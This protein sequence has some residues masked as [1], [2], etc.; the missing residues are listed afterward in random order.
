M[1]IS[2]PGL[3]Y[4]KLTSALR[5]P[6]NKITDQ[7]V[8]LVF[9]YP[10]LVD[11]SLRTYNDLLRDFVA[12]NILKE[13]FV[14]NAINMVSQASQIFPVTD[15][16]GQ[17]TDVAKIT[18]EIEHKVDSY[19]SYN[20]NNNKAISIPRTVDKNEIQQQ[21]K[22]KTNVIRNL[23]ISDPIYKALKPHI[24]LITMDNMID[25]PI[26]V[27]TKSYGIDSL[28]AT[29]ML[30]VCLSE[31]GSLTL[32]DETHVQQIF[33][34]IKTT[35]ASDAWTLLK[36]LSNRPK[37]ERGVII[38]WFL[39][40]IDRTKQF[41]KNMAIKTAGTINTSL[42]KTL[43]KTFKPETLSAAAGG[44][45]LA[46]TSVKDVK[47]RL[48]NIKADPFTQDETLAIL[49]T[50]S[51][52]IE[53]AEL[54][55]KFAL[56]KGLM[57]SQHGVDNTNN[58]ID[59]S[60]Q[61]IGGPV[62]SV[63]DNFHSRFIKTLSVYGMQVIQSY[64]NIFY[65]LGYVVDTTAL[66]RD[67]LDIFETELSKYLKDLKTVVQDNLIKGNSK[68]KVDRLKNLCMNDFS[69][70]DALARSLIDMLTSPG[71]YLNSPIFDFND[72]ERYSTKLDKI[73]SKTSYNISRFEKSFI[74]LVE[75]DPLLSQIG[76]FINDFFNGLQ[77][78]LQK[79]YNVDY[80]NVAIAYVYDKK[81]ALPK[82]NNQQSLNKNVI[83]PIGSASASYI[84]FL[85][86][87]QLQVALCEFVEIV[88]VQIE[89]ATENALD[90]PN[91]VLVIPVETC[92]AI[93]NAVVARSWKDITQTPGE[94]RQ[95][96]R[97][98]ND[99]YVK[100]IVKY[101]S[102]KIKVPNLIVIDEKRGDIYYK[103]MYNSKPQKTSLRSL[104]SFIKSIKEN[105]L[106]FKNESFY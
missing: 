29:M 10:M 36:N 65:P 59:F 81:P 56:N 26:I 14:S 57:Y 79:H 72:F 58:K 105:T 77:T 95:L 35:D 39:K 60:N 94:G 68:T 40:K 30:A 82:I 50:V 78:E 55:F 1:N 25:V 19:G 52:N 41:A 33:Q 100:E 46:V 34:K 7:Q 106:T 84:Y 64:V 13:I 69:D 62:D 101:I 76:K 2:N 23:L 9:I 67:K 61:K 97:A 6:S 8:K 22:R 49:N 17:A 88:D 73:Y 89:I 20:N 83:D 93:A 45:K 32:R 70:S 75:E 92:I 5:D 96:A 51:D 71:N 11:N 38:A 86:L 42:G 63:F 103:M 24:E 53:Q 48:T 15:E 80:S 37:Q 66:I 27:G 99:N 21:I 44:Y 28:V 12:V 98:I 87:W 54:F 16:R 4:S 31:N 74:Q 91:Y 85:F 90:F 104:E 102:K 43:Q 47:D 18:G 3:Q